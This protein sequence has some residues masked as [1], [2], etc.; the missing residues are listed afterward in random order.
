MEFVV[1]IFLIIIVYLS[2][3]KNQRKENFFPYPNNYSYEKEYETPKKINKKDKRC[4]NHFL[5]NGICYPD[6]PTCT[7][8]CRKYSPNGLQNKN[9]CL[10][11][12]D[13]DVIC[14]PSTW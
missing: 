5:L 9:Y 13:G 8:E 12:Y 1:I 2:C 4:K 14:Y 6:M 3:V 11:N 7:K 10:D